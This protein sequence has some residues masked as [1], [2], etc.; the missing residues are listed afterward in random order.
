VP[1]SLPSPPPWSEAIS[2][3]P[4][5]IICQICCNRSYLFRFYTH[6]YMC[7]SRESKNRPILCDCVYLCTYECYVWKSYKC[8][9]CT[10]T[11]MYYL[12]AQ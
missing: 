1:A 6:C 8:P 11:S 2:T 3:D 7:H 4:D 10:C 12:K 9:I 5:R